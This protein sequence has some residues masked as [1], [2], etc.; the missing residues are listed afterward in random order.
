MANPDEILSDARALRSLVDVLS[1]AHARTP[2][3]QFLEVVALDEFTHDVVVRVT[4][5]VF[6]VFDT[7]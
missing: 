4:P 2:P 3:A 1:W 5:E 6:A 7:T